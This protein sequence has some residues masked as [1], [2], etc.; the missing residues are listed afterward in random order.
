MFRAGSLGNIRVALILVWGV[1]FSSW[2]DAAYKLDIGDAFTVK[3]FGEPELTVDVVLDETGAFDYPFVGRVAAI[4]RTVDEL[5]KVIDR[6]LR[7]DYIIDPEVNVAVNKY[8][9]F[10]IKGEVKRPGGYPYQPGLTVI[11]AVTLAGG[12]TERASKDKLLVQRSGRTEIFRVKAN[13]GLGPGDILT[14]EQSL[15]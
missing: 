13:S 2:A 1:F 4:G 12:F 14:V 11:Q 8:R 15:F 6:G 3:V 5:E 10:F 7:G 9:N